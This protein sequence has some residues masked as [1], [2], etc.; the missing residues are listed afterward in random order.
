MSHAELRTR[1][2]VLESAVELLQQVDSDGQPIVALCFSRGA[3]GYKIANVL[4]TSHE[5]KES[6]GVKEEADRSSIIGVRGSHGE[7]IPGRR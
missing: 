4:F 5:L 3:S 6:R 7:I 1:L 2:L